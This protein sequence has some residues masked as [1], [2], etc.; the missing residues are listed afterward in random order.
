M[1]RL[2]KPEPHVC[3]S[4][5]R[6]DGHSDSERID[7]TK[8]SEKPESLEESQA[9]KLSTGVKMWREYQYRF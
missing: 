8:G 3:Q 9:E 4:K 6:R 1:S 7:Q 5:A 2:D